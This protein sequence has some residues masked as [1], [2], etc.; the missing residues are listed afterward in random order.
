V[1]GYEEA[2][3]LYVQNRHTYYEEHYFIDQS[4]KLPYLDAEARRIEA[5]GTLTLNALLDAGKAQGLV[6]S[7]DNR[8][9]TAYML[10]AANEWINL[11]RGD[12]QLLNDEHIR[13]AFDLCW[14]GMKKGKE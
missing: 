4:A 13:E 2:A 8:L 5:E 14:T 3:F 1:C 12:E 11:L 7:V 9:L 6:R 10:G